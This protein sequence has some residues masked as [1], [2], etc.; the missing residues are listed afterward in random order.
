VRRS[1]HRVER[2]GKSTIL[3][4]I[5]GLLPPKAGGSTPMGTLV[6]GVNAALMNDLTVRRM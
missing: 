2:S 3:R 1:D 5:A 4:A 6:A